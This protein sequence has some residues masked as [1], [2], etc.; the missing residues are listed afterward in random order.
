VVFDDSWKPEYDDLVS[1][2]VRQYFGWPPRL[3][4]AF[5][6][7]RDEYP[8]S[9]KRPPVLDSRVHAKNNDEYKGLSCMPSSFMSPINTQRLIITSSWLE[10]CA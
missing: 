7:G 3:S 4:Q 1:Q 2:F 5:D 9:N 10:S 6:A 8:W